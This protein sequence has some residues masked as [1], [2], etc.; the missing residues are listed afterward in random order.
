[1]TFELA[2]PLKISMSAGSKVIRWNYCTR[3]NI[4]KG[5]EPGNEATPLVNSCLIHFFFMQVNEEIKG[6]KIGMPCI[7]STVI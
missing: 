5:R 2:R 6:D 7:H 3:M 4:R 1:M